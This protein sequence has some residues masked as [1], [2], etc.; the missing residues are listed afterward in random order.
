[1]TT[2]PEGVNVPE[3]VEGEDATVPTVT[4]ENVNAN[5][6]DEAGVT[7]V[8]VNKIGEE[9]TTDNMNNANNNDGGDVDEEGEEDGAKK[10]VKSRRS[11][12]IKTM[13]GK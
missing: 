7:G 1:M 11:T 8:N 5:N 9:G 3:N 2:I 10:V 6:T 4:E 12:G 13:E